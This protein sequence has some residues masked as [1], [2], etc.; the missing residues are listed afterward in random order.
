MNDIGVGVLTDSFTTPP[1][2]VGV[3]ERRKASDGF[4]VEVMLVRNGSGG[5]ITENL[6]VA[7][8]SA[9]NDWYD[10]G[11]VKIAAKGDEVL[12]ITPDGM[13]SVADGE[14]FFIICEGRAILTYG[15]S[16]GI[17]GGT[18][19]GGCVEVDGNDSDGG[20][21]VEKVCRDTLRITDFRE[22]DGGAI[23]ESG[24]DAVHFDSDGQVEFLEWD[25]GDE[26]AILGHFVVPDDYD[27]VRDKCSIVGLWLQTGSTDTITP[28]ND[29]RIIRGGVV[30]G[31]DLNPTD[32]ALSQGGTA[33]TPEKVTIDLSG[34]SLKAG[35]IVAWEVATGTHAADAVSFYG[36]SLVG[37]SRSGRIRAFEATAVDDTEVDV[38][39]SRGP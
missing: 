13:T 23:T 36:A 35:D 26:E 39:I 27:E 19:I 34:N 21:I 12:G 11:E 28:T 18:A 20:K 30:T 9:D 25:A 16:G 7:P 3:R 29:V 24:T 37:L 31:A 1:C 17:V 22:A 4:M 33:D 32:V 5:A 14:Y 2:N 15:D 10:A 38:I 6:P 8:V